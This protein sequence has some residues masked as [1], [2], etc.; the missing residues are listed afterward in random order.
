MDMNPLR[1]LR[2]LLIGP[3]RYKWDKEYAAGRWDYLHG[4]A[5]AD[6]YQALVDFVDL[7]LHGT[8]TLL[9]I[10]CGEGIL[11][12][13]IPPGAY[14]L[15]LGIDIS[16]VAIRR[17]SRHK[18]PITDYHAADMETYEPPG[19]FAMI[20]FNEVL[21]YSPD[22]LSLVSR[23]LPYLETNGHL[24]VSLNETP[25]SLD[26]IRDLEKIV[27]LVDQKRTVHERGAWHCKVYSPKPPGT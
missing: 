2:K 13:R 23:F 20:I 16:H 17:A 6:R 21:Y 19:K 4:P 18:D 15:F 27:S 22:H 10:G 7:Y 14:T 5:Q 11:Q 9:E 24:L 1:F 26:I 12:E 8:R 3:E 25:K